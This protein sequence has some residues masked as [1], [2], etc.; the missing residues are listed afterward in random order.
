MLV[1]E[2]EDEDGEAADGGD[3]TTDSEEEDEEEEVSGGVRLPG[4]GVCCA[5]WPPVVVMTLAVTAGITCCH[6]PAEALDDE[7]PNGQPPFGAAA[8]A[9]LLPLE[10]EDEGAG[11]TADTVRCG[12]WGGDGAAI[13]TTDCCGWGTEAGRGEDDDASTVADGDGAA[14]ALVVLV[15]EEAASASL[16]RWR[17]ARNFLC[18][19]YASS[20]RLWLAP[21]PDEADDEDADEADDDDDDDEPTDRMTG[22]MVSP[23]WARCCAV[24]PIRSSSADEPELARCRM[25]GHAPD[26]VAASRGAAAEAADEMPPCW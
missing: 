8:A 21:A 17:M 4:D 12:C 14:L 13:A 5:R 2:E 24:P 11:E 23:F 19:L 10:D 7:P 20:I 22:V 18:G 26:R 16:S 15:E 25:I 6:R 3:E 1:A 9:G